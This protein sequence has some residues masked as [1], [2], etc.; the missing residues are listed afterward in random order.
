M[1]VRDVDK[2][3]GEINKLDWDVLRMTSEVNV[4][5]EKHHK[6][7]I[8]DNPDTIILPPVMEDNAQTETISL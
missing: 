2:G 5:K 6:T 1:Y 8:K 4:F 3:N 7:K